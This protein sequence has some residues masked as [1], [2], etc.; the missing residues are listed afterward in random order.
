MKELCAKVATGKLDNLQSAVRPVFTDPLEPELAE[1]A[2]VFVDLQTTRHQADYAPHRPLA[3]ARVVAPVQQAADAFAS[4]RAVKG[5]D[6]ANA[7]C[8]ALLL[9][10]HWRAD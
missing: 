8:V 6:N 2:Q 4:W 3:A 10:K 9:H 5:A 1:D 7:F